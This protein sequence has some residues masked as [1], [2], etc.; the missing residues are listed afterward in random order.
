MNVPTLAAHALWILHILISSL[1]S[2]ERKEKLVFLSRTV[3]TW[4]ARGKAM[5][6]FLQAVQKWG[7]DWF[8]TSHNWHILNDYKSPDTL[9]KSRV[10]L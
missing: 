2:Q 8:L 4:F 6:G 1:R 5:L 10:A 9:L 3:G 7:F